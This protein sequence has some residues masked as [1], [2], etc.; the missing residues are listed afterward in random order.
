MDLLCNNEQKVKVTFTGMDNAPV[1]KPAPLYGPI[2]VSVVN[3]DGSFEVEADG[4][5]AYFASGPGTPVPGTP[6]V[7][8]FHV[9]AEGDPTPGV[10]PLDM[11]V[12]LHATLAEA[13]SLGAV[14]SAPEFK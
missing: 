10:D 11:D 9:H 14:A 5:S 2:A 8:Q 12:Y 13:A 4:V 3:G 7:T 1:P 6:L